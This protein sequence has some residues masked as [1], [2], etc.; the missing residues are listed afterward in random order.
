[1]SFMQSQKHSMGGELAMVG[2]LEDASLLVPISTKKDTP[3][4]WASI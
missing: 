2:I 4:L 3:L 1:M